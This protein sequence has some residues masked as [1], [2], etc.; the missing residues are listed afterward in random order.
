MASGN[1]QAADFLFLWRQYVHQIDDLID[2]DLQGP[3][4]MLN[5]FMMAAFVYT[6]PFFLAHLQELRQ[7]AVNCTNAYADSVAW[8]KKDGWQKEF[9]DHYRHFGVEMVLAVA[10]MCGGYNHMREVS[11]VLREMCWKE[12]HDEK[13]NAV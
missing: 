9:A 10:G 13:G 2:G 1:E 11:P 7:I 6:H 4:G 8:E 3:E 5:T 12:H